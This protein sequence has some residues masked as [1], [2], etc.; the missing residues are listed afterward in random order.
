L[1]ENTITVLFVVNGTDHVS[2]PP[3]NSALG[4]LLTQPSVAMTPLSP[5]P[6]HP[7]VHA[8]HPNVAALPKPAPPPVKPHSPVVAPPPV[9]IDRPKDVTTTHLPMPAIISDES[10]SPKVVPKPAP[11]GATVC[12]YHE[13]CI[14]TWSAM[15]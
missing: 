12:K 10:N 3:P 11:P 6:T 15:I 13:Q 1:L 8:P 7:M 14:V 4:A 5:R 9:T 2:V